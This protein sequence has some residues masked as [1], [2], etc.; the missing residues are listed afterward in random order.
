MSD[1]NN[2]PF[3]ILGSDKVPQEGGVLGQ[4]FRFLVRRKEILLIKRI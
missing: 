4:G 2:N 3:N 1:D